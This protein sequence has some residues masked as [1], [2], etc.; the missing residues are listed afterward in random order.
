MVGA[1]VSVAGS[2]L[3]GRQ[4]AQAF[5]AV[6]GEPVRYQP[7]SPDAIRASGLP[8]AD[9]RANM[10]AYFVA[11]EQDIVDLVDDELLRELNPAIESFDTW[12]AQ[13]KDGLQLS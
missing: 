9:E 12:L 10:Q 11:A 13:H 8:G 5:S 3:T 2:V 1:T 4:Y 6:L 7:V